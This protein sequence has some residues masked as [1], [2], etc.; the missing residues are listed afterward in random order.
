M[1]GID[2]PLTRV[3]DKLLPKLTSTIEPWGYFSR[4]MNFF[5]KEHEDEQVKRYYHKNEDLIVKTLELVDEKRRK[6]RE[7]DNN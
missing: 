7:Y 1:T 2:D 6:Q 3:M 4:F 5:L